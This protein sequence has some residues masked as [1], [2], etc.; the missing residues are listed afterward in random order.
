MSP[1]NQ[2]LSIVT[3][4]FNMARY[5]AGTMDSVLAN[6]RL[7]DE[8]FIIDG[9]STDGSADVIRKYES[10]LTAWISEPD[11]GYADALA[12][13]FARATG[14]ILCWINAGDLLLPGALD[15]ARKA[16]AETGADMIFGD[17]FY[18]DEEGRV[19]FLSRG[20]VNDLCASMLYGG[21]TPLQDA[22]FWTRSLYCRVGGIDPGLR[23]AA[24]YDLFLRMALQGTCRYV[25]VT[26]SSFR[27][28]PGQKSIA[29]SPA[30]HAERSAVRRRELERRTESVPVRFLKMFWHGL[31]IRWRVHVQ[32]QRWR[33]NDLVGH[34]ISELRCQQYW[35]IESGAG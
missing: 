21:W 19:I 11:R 35:P 34:P 15:A 32:Q 27:R 13:G 7:G 33:R 8:Y 26:F 5:L 17:D 10:R 23:H 16:I 14:D 4:N 18:I 12:K 28:H 22:C 24:D 3:P 25:P 2:T 6:V 20:H 31:M 9:G 30:Y 29:G 1:I